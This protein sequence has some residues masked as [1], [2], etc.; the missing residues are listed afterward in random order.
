MYDLLGTY[1]RRPCDPADVDAEYEPEATV[2]VLEAAIA[3][4]GHRSVRLGAPHELLA[5]LAKGELPELDAALTIAEGCG[6]RNREAWAPVLLE[7]R[8]DPGLGSDALTLVRSRSTRPGRARWWRPP[9]SRC[10]TGAWCARRTRR[11]RRR[12]RGP[13]RSS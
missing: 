3:R 2:Q 8:G 13:F 12:C 7:M 4:L 9:A 5:R 11:G 6:G 10:P 1:P